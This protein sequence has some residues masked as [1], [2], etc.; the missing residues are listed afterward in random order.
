MKKRLLFLLIL[1]F[2]LLAQRAR[3]ALPIPQPPHWQIIGHRDAHGLASAVAIRGQRAYLATGSYLEILDISD[4]SQPR[5]LFEIRGKEGGIRHMII[6]GDRLYALSAQGVWVF[7]IET[8]DTLTF[9][10]GDYVPGEPLSMEGSLVVIGVGDPMRKLLFMDFAQPSSP[11]Q[12]GQYESE[13]DIATALLSSHHLYLISTS[14]LPERAIL[15]ILDVSVPQQPQYIGHALLDNRP[16]DALYR[17]NDKLFIQGVY[18]HAIYDIH[19]ERQPQLLGAVGT[20]QDPDLNTIFAVTEDYIFLGKTQAGYYQ[21]KGFVILDYHDPTAP[22]VVTSYWIHKGKEDYGFAFADDLVFMARGSWGLQL[23]DIS[24]IEHPAPVGRYRVELSLPTAIA[25]EDDRAY[26]ADSYSLDVY[27][28][29]DP[30]QPRP[31]SQWELPESHIREMTVQDGVAYLAGESQIFIIDTT[32]PPATSGVREI[33]AVNSWNSTIRSIPGRI[34]YLHNSDLWV[35]EPRGNNPRRLIEGYF[36]A[37]DVRLQGD[38]RLVYTFNDPF[39]FAI[40]DV[41]DE[42]NVIEVAHIQLQ[43]VRDYYESP[44]SHVLARGN[45]V[46]LSSGE[47]IDVS[48]PAHPRQIGFQRLGGYFYERID[49][50]GGLFLLPEQVLGMFDPSLPYVAGGYPAAMGNGNALFVQNDL[51]Y[52]VN[53]GTGLWVLRPLPRSPSLFRQEAEDGQITPPMGPQW[54]NTACGYRYVS[55]AQAWSDGAVEFTIHQERNENVFLW[56]RVMGMDWNQ[57]SF[58]VQWDDQTPLHFEIV[59]PDGQWHWLLVDTGNPQSHAFG[60]TAG[61]HTLRFK[62]REGNA[63]LDAFLITNHPD[64]HPTDA[65]PCASPLTPTPT[66]TPTPTLTPTPTPIPPPPTPTPTPLPDLNLQ[67]AGSWGGYPLPENQPH[68]L[69]YHD[70]LLMAQGTRLLAYDFSDPAQP[71]LRGRSPSLPGYITSLARQ[72]RW[73]YLQAGGLAIIDLDDLDHLYLAAHMPGWPG[74][75]QVD[76]DRLYMVD[77]PRWRIFDIT[78]PDAPELIGEINYPGGPRTVQFAH[79][80]AFV[81]ERN[82]RIAIYDLNNP[83]R[84]ELLS[85]YVL[86]ELDDNFPMWSVIQRFQVS[87]HFLYV[88]SYHN[89]SYWEYEWSRI[90]II[91]VSDPSHPQP[92]GA[93]EVSGPYFRP[94]ILKKLYGLAVEGDAIFT[95]LLFYYRDVEPQGPPKTYHLLK[96]DA[97]DPDHIQILGDKIIEEGVAAPYAASQD[98]VL[99]SF[100]PRH[101]DLPQHWTWGVF[102]AHSMERLPIDPLTQRFVGEPRARDIGGAGDQLFVWDG[103]GIRMLDNSQPELPQETD[104]YT[105][106]SV[107]A[108]LFGSHAYLGSAHRSLDYYAMITMCV[109]DLGQGPEAPCHPMPVESRFDQYDHNTDILAES[110]G[111]GFVLTW[112][113]L[114]RP[115]TTIVD[116]RDLEHMQVISTT[117]R[118]PVDAVV[119]PLAAQNLT[120]W[121]ENLNKRGLLTLTPLHAPDRPLA[122]QELDAPIRHMAQEGGNLVILTDKSLKLFEVHETDFEERG[123]ITLP[124][125]Q[126]EAHALSLFA[127]RAYV[128]IGRDLR[129][130]DILNPDQP[131]EIARYHAPDDILAIY[132]HPPYVSLAANSAGV[133]N[134]LEANPPSPIYLPGIQRQA[135]P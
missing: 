115:N 14:N 58:W 95:V 70:H 124:R 42:A 62:T 8:N 44:V 41:T 100:A 46:Y 12:V 25:V 51:I 50:M 26:V 45:R 83:H 67:P 23:L 80:L 94:G 86:P 91:D 56:A 109:A 122:Q 128:A 36:H 123:A 10:G 21:S 116:L 9:L 102:D 131:V 1:I 121:A 15:S 85:Y 55:D 75:V 101:P 74:Q 63:R 76:G 66:P 103:F 119:V 35:M 53:Q 54:D 79:R 40:Y 31:L 59:P 113:S 22:T 30:A 34:Y 17:Y 132:V 52:A 64:L 96:L 18:Y 43:R 88:K 3:A 2:P 107:L 112:D 33:S 68:A 134:L 38:K 135:R 6:D 111:Y 97:R 93:F 92:R 49:I 77:G 110:Q 48:D 99:A 82:Q 47:V 60:L 98:L 57:N 127:G 65:Q 78:Q 104:V 13:M 126:G 32:Q 69:P 89:R 108:R 125:V 105:H 90:A 39:Y 129:V 72:E 87:G 117:T 7:R 24:D 19:D 27:D 4:P 130:V 61:T 20:F 29:S 81:L 133:I 118:I 73:L 71:Q 28:V 84:L 16:Y 106:A 11:K 37:F 114:R 5:S 120:V